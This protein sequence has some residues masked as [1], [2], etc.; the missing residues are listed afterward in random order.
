ML[1]REINGVVGVAGIRS[2]LQQP[3][4][5]FYLKHLYPCKALDWMRRKDKMSHV[6]RS[7]ENSEGI[8]AHTFWSVHRNCIKITHG[9]E[10]RDGGIERDTGTT[11]Y[12][13][14]GM[15]KDKTGTL[16]C[17]HTRKR[18]SFCK[19]AQHLHGNCILFQCSSV[20]LCV[21]GRWGRGPLSPL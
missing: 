14:Q 19:G 20:C 13:N 1:I 6:Y 8:T 21:F 11:I 10:T 7:H 12:I 16:N 3:K 9:E 17:S 5:V 18:K 2:L 15:Q 4:C